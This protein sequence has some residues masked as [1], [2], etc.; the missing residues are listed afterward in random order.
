M[1]KIL[2]LFVALFTLL[3]VTNAQIKFNRMETCSD[4]YILNTLRDGD[5]HLL[6][7]RG[8]YVLVLRNYDFSDCHFSFPIGKTKEEAIQSLKGFIHIAETIKDETYSF[9]DDAPEKQFILI[10][11][12]EC[13]GEIHLIK[14]PLEGYIRFSKAE[15][16]SLLQ[17][18]VSFG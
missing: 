17:S 5:I 8:T 15:L 2:V 16:N 11:K 18:V 6:F 10:I 13:E 7:D 4:R 14:Y 12:G 3:P 9:V 1:K